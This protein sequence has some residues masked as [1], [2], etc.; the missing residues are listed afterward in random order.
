MRTLAAG[1]HFPE[2]PEGAWAEQAG[3]WALAVA[4]TAIFLVLNSLFVTGHLR[5]GWA[6][7]SGLFVLAEG[8][9]VALL[10]QGG[11]PKES[12]LLAVGLLATL[13][14]LLMNGSV[15]VR[16]AGSGGIVSMLSALLAAVSLGTWASRWLRTPAEWLT[17]ILCAAVGDAWFTV[18][19]VTQGISDGHPLAWMRMDS[20][21]GPANRMAP[22]FM[23]LF[24]VA[25]YL[26]TGKRF[27]LR[28]TLL[29][30]GA[31][32]GYAGA[33]VISL[34]TWQ[35]MPALPLVGLGVLAGAWS[36]LHC[37]PRDVLRGLVISLVLFVL[38]LGLVFV[39]RMLHPAPQRSPEFFMPRDMAERTVPRPWSGASVGC[40]G[41]LRT[42]GAPGRA[43]QVRRR[44][45][46]K[47][48]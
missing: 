29:T 2:P 44:S 6:A 41:V 21:T 27:G 36:E 42:A 22:V 48:G 34:T 16:V 4:L 7:L 9:V 12:W 28:V 26:E 38:L 11:R 18:L 19:N 1:T 14:G 35:A 10:I 3:R 13:V 33:E 24:F 20:L 37:P 46:E 30:F 25:L 45:A 47:Y 15:L 8:A 17:V 32:A 39:R 43:E 40:D 31:L 5:P 23:D